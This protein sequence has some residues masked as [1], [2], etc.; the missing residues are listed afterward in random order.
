MKILRLGRL[1]YTCSGG[2]VFHVNSKCQKRLRNGCV[3]WDQPEPSSRLKFDTQTEGPGR[4]K[5]ERVWISIQK[6]LTI[7][8]QTNTHESQ[9]QTF[10]QMR[11]LPLCRCDQL[12]ISHS[13]EVGRYAIGVLSLWSALASTKKGRWV[14]S[15]RLS[16]CGED[17]VWCPRYL[18]WPH[19]RPKPQPQ[20]ARWRRLVEGTCYAVAER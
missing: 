6:S 8:Y 15:L 7:L 14:E 17:S 13:P 19:L 1:L 11:I 12:G 4:C 3:N 9:F 18:Y 16:G 2:R 5:I 20:L 10:Q